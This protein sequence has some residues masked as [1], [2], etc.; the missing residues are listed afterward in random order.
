MKM[1]CRNCRKQIKEWHT[2]EIPLGD[3][4]KLHWCKRCWTEHIDDRFEK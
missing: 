4:P 1:K 3:E 2:V